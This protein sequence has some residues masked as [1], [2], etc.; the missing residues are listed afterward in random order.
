MR[1]FETKIPEVIV[2]KSD[3]YKD[4]RGFF[5]ELVNI[6]SLKEIGVEFKLVQVNHSYNINAGTLRGLHFQVKPFEQTKIVTCLKGAIFDV[7]VDIRPKSKTFLK[8]ITFLISSPEIDLVTIQSEI[9]Q[10]VDF[11]IIYPDK[12]LIP[13][14]FAHGYLT[15]VPS[16]EVLYFTDNMY[17][18]DHDRTIR[19][20]DPQIGITWPKV[21]GALTLS[22]KDANAPL[23][24]E[25]DFSQLT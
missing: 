14:G 5:S 6:E 25:I 24:G 9:A 1:T 12:V 23:L 8:F 4:E 16:T 22:T 7:A 20:D 11:K 2:I 3:M 17:S 18:K 13:K 10:D 19:F 21:G 15:L